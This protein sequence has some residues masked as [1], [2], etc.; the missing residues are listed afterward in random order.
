MATKQVLVHDR[1]LGPAVVLTVRRGSGLLSR[2][3]M[4]DS[5]SPLTLNPT[6][7]LLR[8]YR[9]RSLYRR[10]WTWEQERSLGYFLFFTLVYGSD[11]RHQQDN[12]LRAEMFITRSTDGHSICGTFGRDHALL[13]RA[14]T[15]EV[16]TRD[17]KTKDQYKRST[18]TGRTG[19]KVHT[20]RVSSSSNSK[21]SYHCHRSSEEV[22][23]SM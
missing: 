21:Y 4:H 5:F 9:L 2:Y 22:I 3:R 17:R 18:L 10:A 8:S 15:V 19:E 12:L 11:Y 23:H 6:I 13:Y 7:E 16:A 1:A 14:P 20:G